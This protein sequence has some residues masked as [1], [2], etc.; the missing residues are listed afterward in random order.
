MGKRKGRPVAL[1][2]GRKFG[3]MRRLRVGSNAFKVSRYY[4]THGLDAGG[5][6]PLSMDEL[7]MDVVYANL[8]R[9]IAGDDLQAVA[10]ESLQTSVECDEK[11]R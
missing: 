7:T 3:I 8:M 1:I 11:R 9:Q 6:T 5:K 10:G 4:H 2:F